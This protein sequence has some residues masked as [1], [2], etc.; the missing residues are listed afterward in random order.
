MLHRL[1]S[2]GG[3]GVDIFQSYINIHIYFIYSEMQVK[4]SKSIF[5]GHFP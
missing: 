2:M 4:Y 1:L 5:R 3:I